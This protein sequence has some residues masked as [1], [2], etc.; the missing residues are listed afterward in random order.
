V[1]EPGEYEQKLILGST[2][3]L[4]SVWL[5][6]RPRLYAHTPS[7]QASQEGCQEGKGGQGREGVKAEPSSKRPRSTFGEVSTPKR[8]TV[9]RQRAGE[10]GKGL[11]EEEDLEG[12]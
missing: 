4:V 10:L 11:L 3:K 7:A 2:R 12:L 5:Y 6:W 1:I 8:F 9:T